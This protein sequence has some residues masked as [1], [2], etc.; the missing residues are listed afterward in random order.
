MLTMNGL[1]MLAVAVA[2]VVAIVVVSSASCGV[3]SSWV[4]VCKRSSKLANTQTY[5]KRKDVR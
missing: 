2:A 5:S 4:L 3:D 1:V